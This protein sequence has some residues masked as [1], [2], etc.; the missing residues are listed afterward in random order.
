M[1]LAMS[2]KSLFIQTKQGYKKTKLQK[3]DLIVVYFNN[4]TYT[5]ISFARPKQSH[6]NQLWFSS[7]NNSE[8]LNTITDLDDKIMINYSNK[9]FSLQIQLL[10]AATG[11]LLKEIEKNEIR[12]IFEL[13]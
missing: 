7:K 10:T 4:E 12:V 5:F 11:L 6:G 2:N 13:V 3:G 1:S 9:I 8:E